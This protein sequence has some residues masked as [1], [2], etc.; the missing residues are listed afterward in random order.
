[1]DF[2]AFIL[3]LTVFTIYA[4]MSSL[5]NILSY[6]C[7]VHFKK[8]ILPVK[9]KCRH[10]ESWYSKAPLPPT[11]PCPAHCN[12]H[13]HTLYSSLALAPWQLTTVY[14]VKCNSQTTSMDYCPPV[15][16]VSWTGAAPESTRVQTPITACMRFWWL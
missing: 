9:L 7:R 15:L 10:L 12:T 16:H 6:L 5:S 14:Q 1:M 8:M 3:M 13:T 2:K 11:P 4:P